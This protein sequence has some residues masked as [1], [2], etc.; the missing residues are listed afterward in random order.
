MA[1]PVDPKAHTDLVRENLL[2]RY[3]SEDEYS[4]FLNASEFLKFEEGENIISQGEVSQ[5]LY[6]LIQGSV[7][8]SAHEDDKDVPVYDL[9]EG[10][11]F[12]EA[13]LFLTELRTADVRCSGDAL[14]LRIHRKSLFKFISEFAQAGNRV[15]IM[16]IFSLLKKLKASTKEIATVKKQYME[17][18]LKEI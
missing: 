12:G 17:N 7:T 15:L 4:G 11:I 1:L 2:F 3:M 13:A 6:G 8:V 16:I 18:V 9:D 5:F 10:D 14:V